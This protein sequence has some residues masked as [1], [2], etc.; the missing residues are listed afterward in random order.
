VQSDA[1]VLVVLKTTDARTETLSSRVV[2]L[3]PYEIPE[4]LLLEVGGGHEPYLEWVR[5]ETADT[6]ER[7]P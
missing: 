3:H 7:T 5:E 1:E 2:E 6:R 4:V